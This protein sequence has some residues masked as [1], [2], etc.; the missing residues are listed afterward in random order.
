AVAA[1]GLDL[2]GL[3]TED[4]I[5]PMLRGL[6]RAQSRRRAAQAVAP[7]EAPLAQRLSGLSSA[8]RERA[9]ADLVRNQVA[10]VLGYGDPGDVDDERSFLDLGF[11]SLTAVELRNQL[12]AATGLRL[13]TTLAFDHPTPA[14][15]AA[16]L[17]TELTPDDASSDSGATVVLKEIDR[18]EAA[19]RAVAEGDRNGS[20]EQITARLRELIGIA[21]ANG[22]GTGRKTESDLDSATDE[23]L[24]ALVDDLD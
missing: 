15:L 8:E 1:T 19:L 11:D 21:Q 10:A 20:L 12:G 4:A 23:E 9:L 17:A 3:R 24:F 16:H 6:V 7:S 18:L 2:T 5:H 13:P 14:A 22:P